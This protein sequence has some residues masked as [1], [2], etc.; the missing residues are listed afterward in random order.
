MTFLREVTALV[1]STGQRIRLLT[2]SA[3]FLNKINNRRVKNNH[4]NSFVVDYK[5]FSRELRRERSNKTVLAVT[6]KLAKLARVHKLS[7]QRTITNVLDTRRL[8]VIRLW[9]ETLWV[10]VSASVLMKKFPMKILRQRVVNFALP[11]YQQHSDH[12]LKPSRD[13]EEHPWLAAERANHP[14][15]EVSIDAKW[16]KLAVKK[17]N[18]L[19]VKQANSSQVLI[20]LSN[21]LI[22]KK[23]NNSNLMRILKSSLWVTSK[24]ELM[25]T[26]S[27]WTQSLI[28]ILTKD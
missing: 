18:W 12:H 20:K 23:T 1:S 5:W 6:S 27:L 19:W 25:T 2:A 14:L 15:R 26:M 3:E 9:R 8:I 13:K 7:T 22:R 10:N 24:K 16:C 11:N 21:R 4:L 28:A 17:M